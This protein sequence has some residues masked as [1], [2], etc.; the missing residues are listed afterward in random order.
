MVTFV[1]EIVEFSREISWPELGCSTPRNTALVLVV[2]GMTVGY[3]GFVS[4][5]CSFRPLFAAMDR[6]YSFPYPRPG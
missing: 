4:P 2:S 1:D 5:L 6:S 3:L